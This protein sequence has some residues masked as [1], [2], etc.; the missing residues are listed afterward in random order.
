MA[1]PKAKGYRPRCFFDVQ[2]NGSPAGRIIVEL[3]ADICPK[4][5][6]NFRALCTGEKGLSRTSGKALHYKGSGF[7]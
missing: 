1:V 2:I 7:H 6:D 4:T 3:F 5:S